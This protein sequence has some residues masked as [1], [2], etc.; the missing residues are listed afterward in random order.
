MFLFFFFFYR[1]EEQNVSVVIHASFFLFFWG[2]IYHIKMTI[3]HHKSMSTCLNFLSFVFDWNFCVEYLICRWIKFVYISTDVKVY[4]EALILHVV[5]LRVHLYVTRPFAAAAWARS[6]VP[7]LLRKLCHF[8]NGL[9]FVVGTGTDEVML[10]RIL[11]MVRF[12]CGKSSS[13]G[14]T[15]QIL[16]VSI[17][18]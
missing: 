17:W 5:T 10:R 1:T 6:G 3:V 12:R 11:Q 7:V 9:E 14:F 15:W 4:E 18:A 13:V 16:V 8:E 2:W